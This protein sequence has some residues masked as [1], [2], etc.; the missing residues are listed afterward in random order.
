M[1]QQYF[2]SFVGG[3]EQHGGVLMS[4]VTAFYIIFD[5]KITNV[6]GPEECRCSA[7]YSFCKQ[8]SNMLGS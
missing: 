6:S 7:H 1:L 4:A 5:K 3:D 2:F 8:M